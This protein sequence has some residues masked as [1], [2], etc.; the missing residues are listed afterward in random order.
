[1]PF[2][3]LSQH[4]WLN[5]FSWPHQSGLFQLSPPCLVPS[6]SSVFHP[7]LL[8]SSLSSLHLVMD[9]GPQ[10]HP[11]LISLHTPL[12]PTPHLFCYTLCYALPHLSSA[13]DCPISFFSIILLYF[14][15]QLQLS[16]SLLFLLPSPPLQPI[17]IHAF[18]WVRAPMGSQ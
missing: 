1:M 8:A 9:S 17:P 3:I 13:P 14:T 5:H 16:L 15:F 6:W 4:F 2:Y 12:N 18:Q 11:R 7:G 10:S